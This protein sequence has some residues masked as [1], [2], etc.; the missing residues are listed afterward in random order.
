[1]SARGPR[2]TATE[3]ERELF[4]RTLADVKPLKPHV[5]PPA[6]PKKASP[7][8][9]PPAKPKPS[10]K[11]AKPLPRRDSEPPEIGGHRATHLRRGR[12]EPEA[13]LDLHGMTQETAH[14]ALLRFLQRGRANGARVVLVITGKS[15]VL[16]RE[17]KLWLA[18]GEL[19]PLVSG[20]SSAHV[21]HGGAGASYILLKRQ[22]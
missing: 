14:R 4:Y 22:R 2:R 6:R 8:P 16:R 10:P 15:G 13:T 9:K 12:M 7:P 20:V 1:M 21:R 11:P 17:L 3:A 18:H 5:K 19:S